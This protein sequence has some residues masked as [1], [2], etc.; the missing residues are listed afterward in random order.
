LE[1]EHLGRWLEMVD[2]QFRAVQSAMI[3]IGAVEPSK[4]RTAWRLNLGVG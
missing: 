4:A 3:V 2:G 1:L